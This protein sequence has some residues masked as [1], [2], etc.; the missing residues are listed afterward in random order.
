MG[1]PEIENHIIDILNAAPTWGGAI[2]SKRRSAEAVTQ[3]RIEA[4]MEVLRAIASNPDNSYYSSLT[5]LVD[6]ENGDFLPA[7]E[8]EPGIPLIIPYP[9]AEPRSGI[10]A[11]PDEIDSYMYDIT[12]GPY[13]A[14][15]SGA[16]D[17]QAVAYNEQTKG[18]RISPTSCRYSIINGQIKFTGDSIQ[19]PLVQIDPSTGDVSDMVPALF[20]P[21]IVKLAIPKLVKEGDNLS[22]Y[23]AAYEKA[24]YIDLASIRAGTNKVSPLAT[25]MMAQKAS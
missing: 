14:L 17:A 24:G 22:V 20:E 23:A 21:L 8:G 25:V 10:P 12:T 4:T 2:N 11:D 13:R 7:H 6:V 19:I 3:A 18:G 5:K 16:V 9:G 1:V 15:Y